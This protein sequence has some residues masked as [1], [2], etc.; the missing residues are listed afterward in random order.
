VVGKRSFHGL[1]CAA[2]VCIVRLAVRAQ[3]RVRCRYR[4]HVHQQGLVGFLVE[5]DVAYRERAKGLSFQI[6]TLYQDELGDYENAAKTY[7]KALEK[8]EAGIEEIGYRQGQCYEKLD[9]IE[10]AVA[11]YEMS[12]SGADAAAPHRIASLAQIG[13]I[14]E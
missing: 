8:G 12:A 13:Q 9:R 5:L 10:Q 14:S 11:S 3:V 2:C 6:A 7:S 1:E 4:D